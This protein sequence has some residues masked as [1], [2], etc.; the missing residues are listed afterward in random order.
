MGAGR[1]VRPLLE[2]MIDLISF[3]CGAVFGAVFWW[4]VRRR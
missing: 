2:T 4:L 1:V 3:L